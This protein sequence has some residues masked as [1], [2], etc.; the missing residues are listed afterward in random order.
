MVTLYITFY[1]IARLV[2]RSRRKKLVVGREGLWYG[3]EYTCK[4]YDKILVK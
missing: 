4:K 2:P 3:A 1:S